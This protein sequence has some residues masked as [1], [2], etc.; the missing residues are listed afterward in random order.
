MSQVCATSSNNNFPA[1][2]SMINEQFNSNT[3]GGD[4]DGD[5]YRR[6]GNIHESIETI[7]ENNVRNTIDDFFETYEKLNHRENRKQGKEVFK[8]YCLPMLPLLWN[9][10]F[11][12]HCRTAYLFLFPRGATKCRRKV[13]CS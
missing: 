11:Q 6:Y 7:K 1:A 10:L 12:G 5:F 2:R 4:F 9:T 8:S 3:F 13:N